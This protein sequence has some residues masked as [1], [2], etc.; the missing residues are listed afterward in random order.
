MSNRVAVVIEFDIPENADSNEAMF[1]IGTVLDEFKEAMAG[2]F[3]VERITMTINDV[4]EKISN[5][6]APASDEKRPTTSDTRTANF[7]DPGL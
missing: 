1:N 6:C 7:L 4:A 2:R 3:H 5:I